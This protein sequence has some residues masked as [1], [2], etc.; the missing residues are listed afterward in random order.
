MRPLL[1]GLP[2]AKQFRQQQMCVVSILY[3]TTH[4]A[5]LVVTEDTAYTTHLTEDITGTPSSSPPT[6]LPVSG[7]G[8]AQKP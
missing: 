4:W 1:P 5:H 6:H 7:L 3:H 2:T 8:A